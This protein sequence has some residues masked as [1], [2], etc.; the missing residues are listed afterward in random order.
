MDSTAMYEYI[1]SRIQ[2]DLLP[3]GY[4]RSGKGGLFYR[5]S[6]EGKVGCAIEMQKSMFNSPG[7][8]SFTFNLGCVALYELNGYYKDKLSLQPLRLATRSYQSGGMRIGHLC[9][10]RD[11]WWEITDG[12]LKMFTLE[13][14]YELFVQKDIQKAAEY[15]DEMAIKKE[16]VY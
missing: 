2:E 9:R 7:V 6:C 1:L 11:Y 13:K 10:G 8:Y 14:Y 12:I 16:N 15:L 4:K 3:Y 5:Y